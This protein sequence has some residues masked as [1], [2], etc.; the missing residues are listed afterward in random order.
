MDIE[1]ERKEQ[2]INNEDKLSEEKKDNEN[3]VVQQQEANQYEEENKK[4]RERITEL[5]NQLREIQNAARVIKAMYENYKMDSERQLKEVSKNTALRMLKM[6][7]PVID[8]L[9]RAFNYFEKSKDLEEFY[10]GTKKIFE[11]FVKLLE[12]EG[13]RSIDTNGKFDPFTHEAMEREER[14]DV[15]EYTILEVIEEGYVYNGQVIKPAKVKVAVKPRKSEP[16]EPKE[17]QE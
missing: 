7:I 9:K 5:E 3:T 1:K 6:L 13:L 2:A 17:E 12:N 16:K 10:N 8:D 15:E 4:L 11:K 14:E